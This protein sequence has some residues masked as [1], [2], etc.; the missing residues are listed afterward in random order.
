[1]ARCVALLLTALLL[2]GCGH[3]FASRKTDE[4]GNIRGELTI[5]GKPLPAAMITFV[6]QAGQAHKGFVFADGKFYVSGIATGPA[7]IVLNAE[8]FPAAETVTIGVGG[9]GRPMKPQISRP[10]TKL[11][12]QF[13]SLTTTPLAYTVKSG[14][15]E[16]KL[17]VPID[18]AELTRLNPQGI[19]DQTKPPTMR[20]AAPQKGRGNRNRP[21]PTKPEEKK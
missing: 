16:Y 7:K 3:S 6:D 12:D 13:L 4:K 17:D 8:E 15:Q 9:S 21:A 2:T 5:N 19:G 1:M 10:K 14:L 20:D 18:P 11:P